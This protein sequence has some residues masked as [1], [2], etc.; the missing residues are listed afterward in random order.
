MAK[1]QTVKKS[2]FDKK[3]SETL[4]MIQSKFNSGLVKTL[5]GTKGK[6]TTPIEGLSWG[7]SSVNHICTGDPF[8][9]LPYGRIVEVFG[10]ESSGKTTLTLHAIAEAQAADALCGF[11]DAEH[12]VDLKY[13]HDL[14]IRT[15]K[16]IFS[17]PDY[18]EQGLE[19]LLEMIRNGVQLVVVDSVAA[20]TPLAEIEG[21]MEKNHMGLQARMMSQALRKLV[22][23]ISKK[24]AVVIFINQIRHKI[25][26]MFGNP[27]V[28]TGGHGLKF[29]ASLRLESVL[30]TAKTKSIRGASD[31]ITGNSGKERLGAS[32]VVRCIKNKV[33][34]PFRETE[35]DVY[36]GKGYDKISD[37]FYLAEKLGVVQACQGGYKIDGMIIKHKNLEE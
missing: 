30:S 9:G 25:G 11:I 26:V 29:Y 14:G 5:T 36:Y 24:K 21:T 27:E 33:A 18:G 13:A 7:V 28:T 2:V 23:V 34:P 6:I 35:V 37:V 22:S 32:A 12:A 31:S 20:L 16:L 19:I 15:D 8:I 3:L 4:S 1:K 10:K 17:Q